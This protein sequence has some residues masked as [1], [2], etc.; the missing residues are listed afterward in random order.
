MPRRLTKNEL[1]QLHLDA[2]EAVLVEVERSPAPLWIALC[3][4]GASVIVLATTQGDY[5]WG[6]I[7]L[8]LVG[9]SFVGGATASVRTFVTSRR[10]VR[11]GALGKRS[12]DRANARVAWTPGPLGETMLVESGNVRLRVRFVRNAD[13]V[14]ETLELKVA[15]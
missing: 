6:A 2:G 1:E 11:I 10:V 14:R 8:G 13:D 5:G 4:L 12:L 3:A 7:V 15:A 9:L